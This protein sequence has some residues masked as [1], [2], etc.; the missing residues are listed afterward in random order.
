[1][2]DTVE[3]QVN[4]GHLTMY[5]EDDS[6]TLFMI[7]NAYTRD[8]NVIHREIFVVTDSGDWQSSNPP[9]VDVTNY[10]E[11]DYEHLR[12]VSRRMGRNLAKYMHDQVCIQKRH[13]CKDDDKR[14]LYTSDIQYF[15]EVARFQ[16]I[17]DFKTL[18]RYW[19][20]INF[21]SLEYMRM[22]ATEEVLRELGTQIVEYYTV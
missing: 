1:M 4:Y 20:Q 14:M 3:M 9:D 8:E 22:N 2:N 15:H 13:K 12:E 18:H 5:T 16:V 11:D 17:D 6:S 7:F 19:D 21:N 10:S